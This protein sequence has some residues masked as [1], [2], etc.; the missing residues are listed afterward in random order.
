MCGAVSLKYVTPKTLQPYL[1]KYDV[2][3]RDLFR[4]Q[5]LYDNIGILKNCERASWLPSSLSPLSLKM[6]EAS[7]AL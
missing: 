7:L 6:L 4:L 1:A 5:L 2:T 3:V